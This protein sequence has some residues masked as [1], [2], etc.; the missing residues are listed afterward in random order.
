MV[1]GLKCV[2]GREFASDVLMK[3]EY[4]SY[5][6]VCADAPPTICLGYLECLQLLLDYGADVN[7][8]DEEGSTLAHEAARNGEERPCLVSSPSLPVC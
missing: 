2:C 6:D 5:V 3:C 7:A 1:N 4:D 8:T